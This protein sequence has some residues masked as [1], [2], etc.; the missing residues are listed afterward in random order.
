MRKVR[1]SMFENA[2]EGLVAS[3]FIIVGAGVLLKEFLFTEGIIYTIL[4][5]V[6]FISII[7]VIPALGYKLAKKKISIPELIYIIIFIAVYLIQTKYNFVIGI[8]ILGIGIAS[9]LQA[10][11]LRIIEEKLEFDLKNL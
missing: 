11:D 5:I 10:L 6:L 8:L 9:L 3:L 7:I 1:E 2:L 4:P